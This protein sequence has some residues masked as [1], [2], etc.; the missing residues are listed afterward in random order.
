M[1][2]LRQARISGRTH[3]GKKRQ[4]RFDFSSEATRRKEGG[5]I[6]KR[7]T[8]FAVKYSP[9]NLEGYSPISSKSGHMSFLWRF[10]S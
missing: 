2:S 3:N 6:E 7:K 4:K 9:L 10:S 8:P 1:V 5:T